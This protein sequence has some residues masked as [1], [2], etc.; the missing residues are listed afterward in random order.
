[1]RVEEE[2]ARQMIEAELG[3]PVIEHDDNSV[4]S[5]YDLRIDYGNTSV[6]V[7]VVQAADGQSIAAWKTIHE[8]GGVWIDD[9]LLGGWNLR[10]NPAA[11]LRNKKPQII[12]LL[13][14]LETRGMNG[15]HDDADIETARRLG[16]LRASRASTTRPGSVYVMVDRPSQAA[17]WVTSKSDCVSE[18]IGE[19]LADPSRADVCHKLAMSESAEAHAMVLVHGFTNAPFGVVDALISDTSELPFKDP[20]L[21]SPISHVWIVSMWTLG[22]G[23]RWS[24]EA[25][26]S[27]FDKLQPR[28]EAKAS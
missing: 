26:W 14:Q 27:R 7:E 8:P 2:W 19:F 15:L 20:A 16:V 12:A 25:G 5:M 10:L 18:W 1:M 17:G 21:P 6:P 22:H 28:T 9:S 11:R 3:C 23:F 13:A 24:S 4:P